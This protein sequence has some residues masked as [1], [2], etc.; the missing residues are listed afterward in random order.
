MLDTVDEDVERGDLDTADAH[1]ERGVHEGVRMKMWSVCARACMLDT[2]DDHV[3]RGDLDTVDEDV[4]RVSST[5]WM[6][7]WMMS[8]RWWWNT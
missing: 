2:V 8:G 6:H 4:E 1:V 3:E 7:M 5:L